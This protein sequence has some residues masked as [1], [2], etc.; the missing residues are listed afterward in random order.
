[1]SGMFGG[2]TSANG[3][4]SANEEEFRP[5]IRRL[6]EFKVRLRRMDDS[7]HDVCAD[8]LCPGHPRS[9]GSRPLRQS[10]S[11]FSAH[12]P[13]QQ[14]YPSTGPSFLCTS[15]FCSGSP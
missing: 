12:S 14:M 6:P 1:M 10:V 15:C 9:S 3:N 8:S 2:P 5:F 4:G 7:I 11:L 13:M